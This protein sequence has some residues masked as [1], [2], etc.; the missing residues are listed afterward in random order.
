MSSEIL[1]CPKCAAQNVYPDGDNHVCADCGHEWPAAGVPEQAETVE[2][3][4]DGVIRDANGVALANGD[5]VVLIKS[6][7]VKGSTTLKQGTKI[8]NIKL[9]SGDHEIDCRV[10]NM[11]LL[12]KAQ[13]VKK[14]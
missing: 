10:D 6:L 11:G 7:K 5:S 9:I 8:S 2:P 12:L 13:Y 1:S 4:D 3:A 14:V